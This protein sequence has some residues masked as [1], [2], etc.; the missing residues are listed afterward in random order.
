M[1]GDF[2]EYYRRQLRKHDQKWEFVYQ[3]FYNFVHGKYT[4]G[5]IDVDLC[6]RFR[7]Y[8]LNARQLKRP[9]RPVSHKSA[10]GYWSTF[11]GL[12][13]IMYRDKLIRTNVNDFLEKID[14]NDIIKDYLS[15]EELWIRR[16]IRLRSIIGYLANEA[17]ILSHRNKIKWP[18]KQ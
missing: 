15:V 12:L 18:T 1:K 5:D 10:A 13:N 7:E 11:R 6:N 8:L 14:T 2:L 4:F 9:E 16:E 17:I 3:H